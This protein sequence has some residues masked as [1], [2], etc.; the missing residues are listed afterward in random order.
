MTRLARYIGVTLEFNHIDRLDLGRFQKVVFRREVDSS[1]N[2]P[3]KSI[4]PFHSYKFVD[5]L[6]ERRRKT[7]EIPLR[8]FA[9]FLSQK[10][11]I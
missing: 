5:G 3:I 7:D 6:L 1:V 8:S 4:G 10:V 2:K 9:T 11:R